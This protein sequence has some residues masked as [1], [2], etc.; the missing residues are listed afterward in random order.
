MSHASPGPEPT[1]FRYTDRSPQEGAVWVLFVSVLFMFSALLT[2]G[3]GIAA[4]AHASWLDSG[5]LPGESTRTWGIV[6]L[7]IA[8]VE[9]FCGL[10]VL[11][12]RRIGFLL[13][14]GLAVL[15][16][17]GHLAVISAYPIWSIVGIALYLLI[18]AILISNRPQR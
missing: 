3:W 10:L 11:F 16:I 17:A 9:G 2:A 12:S 15:G 8:A 1:E 4:L 7:C 14:V 6:L 13:G 5:G 18:I